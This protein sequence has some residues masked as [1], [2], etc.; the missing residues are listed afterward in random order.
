MTSLCIHAILIA[1]LFLLIG[2]FNNIILLH[3]NGDNLFFDMSEFLHG[4]ILYL[5]LYV[6]I[7]E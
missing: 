1:P 3:G 5:L 2:K 4:N 6:E 7:Y